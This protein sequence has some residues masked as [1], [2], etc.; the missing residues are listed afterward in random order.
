M[1]FSIVTLALLAITPALA[2]SW[3]SSDEPEPKPWTSEQLEKAQNVFSN[4]KDSAF[5]TWSESQLRQFLLD[6]GV[7]EPKGTKEQLVQMARNQ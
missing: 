3:L 2:S 7:I 6:Q 1:R 5:D 4:V